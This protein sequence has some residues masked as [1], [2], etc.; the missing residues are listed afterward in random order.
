MAFSGTSAIEADAQIFEKRVGKQVELLA[1]INAK[2]AQFT[3]VNNQYYKQTAS[4]TASD[5]GVRIAKGVKL[6]GD[7]A[8]AAVYLAS[9]VAH[10]IAKANAAAPWYPVAYAIAKALS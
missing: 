2:T 8:A 9:V 10:A 4:I 6:Y 3:E 1:Q 5:V 7:L